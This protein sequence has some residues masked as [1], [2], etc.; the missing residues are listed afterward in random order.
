MFFLTSSIVYFNIKYLLQ[1][2]AKTSVYY[3][4]VQQNVTD[5][6]V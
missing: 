5:K 6:T 4:Q 3:K 1:N 2:S